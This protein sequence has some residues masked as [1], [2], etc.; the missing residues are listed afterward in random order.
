MVKNIF[1]D[2]D[3]VLAESVD[4][5][6][7]AFYLLYKSYGEEIAKKVVKHHLDNGGMSRYEK[8]KLYHKNYLSI[9]L[10]EK[11]I[12]K[13][14][15]KYSKFVVNGVINSKSVA[16]SKKFLNENYNKMAFFLIT[17][18][19]TEEMKYILQKR[20]MINYFNGVF[21]SPEKKDYWCKHILESKNLKREET[22]FL[23]DAL[24]DYNAAKKNN[25]RFILRER[26]G[27]KHLFYDYKG[28]RFKDFF[29]LDNLLNS[30][31]W[32]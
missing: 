3:G 11:E 31:Q 4:V 20:G 24:S 16:G 6:T 27:N 30:L 10:D 8:I 13:Y 28:M 5:K 2:F 23:G 17:G 14:S 21:G 9:D 25:I 19:P 26:N 29:E 18:A 15:K 32:E 7:N 22:I 1:F 12:N